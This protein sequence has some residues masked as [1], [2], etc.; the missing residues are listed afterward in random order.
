MNNWKYDESFIFKRAIYNINKKW[1]QENRDKK[2]ENKHQKL[3]VISKKYMRSMQDKWHSISHI[4]DAIKYTKELLNKEDSVAA[5]Y[6]Q[7]WC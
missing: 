7:H 2:L 1:Y 6:Y 3:I 4:N 5:D